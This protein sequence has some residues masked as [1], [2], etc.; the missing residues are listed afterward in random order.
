MSAVLP[1]VDTL[2]ICEICKKKSLESFSLYRRKNYRDP[3]SSLLLRIFKMFDRL[4]KHPVYI[5]LY[6]IFGYFLLVKELLYAF[7]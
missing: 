5:S 1:K 2:S 7:W 3:L 6:E 4:M